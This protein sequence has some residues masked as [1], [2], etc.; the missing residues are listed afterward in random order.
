MIATFYL[1]LF[2]LTIPVSFKKIGVKYVL[3]EKKQG[4]VII[5]F[6]KLL[7][8]AAFILVTNIW[9]PQDYF[10]YSWIIVVLGLSAKIYMDR[11]YL[12]LQFEKRLV[13]NP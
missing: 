13:K 12:F 4:A 6:S 3:E 11:K 5:L 10:V 7:W 1:G 9:I 8:W 2:M